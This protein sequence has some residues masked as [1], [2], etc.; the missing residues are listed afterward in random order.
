MGVIAVWLAALGLICSWKDPRYRW[1]AAVGAIGV[2]YALGAFTPF[3][4]PFYALAPGLGKARIPVRAIH[5]VNFSVMVLGAYGVDAILDRTAGRW[6]RWIQWSAF[7]LAALVFGSAVVWAVAYR[8]DLNENALLA[9]AVGAV[10]AGVLAAW[11]REALPRFGVAATLIA[12]S[13]IEL[14]GVGTATFSSRYDKERNK[15]IA[16]L[17]DNRDIADYLHHQSGA[18]MKA[19]GSPVRVAVTENDI[20]TNF[21]DWHA[22]DVLQGYMAGVSINL[23][24]AELHTK[25]SQKLFAVTHSV[26]RKQDWDD[27]QQV[28]QGATGIKVWRNPD[29]MPRVWTAHD[30]VRVNNDADLRTAI[31]DPALDFHRKVVVTSDVPALDTCEGD[32]VHLEHRGTD[33]VRIRAR[34][35]CRGMLVLSEPYYPGWTATVDGKPTVVYEVYGALRGIVVDAGFHNVEFKYRPKSVYFGGALTFLGLV[36]TIA[37]S[38]IDRRA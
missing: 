31:Q 21:G 37:L 1:A 28:F 34:L 25:R 3:H 8:Q 17:R 5:F 29:P 2:V 32:A 15:Y 6:L 16:Q 26:G 4:G 12:V 18:A 10:L 9:G 13:L 27:Q 7:A 35:A 30:I 20:P 33:R 38:R 23:T 36:A 14:Y 11:Q 19:G 24:R 22:I